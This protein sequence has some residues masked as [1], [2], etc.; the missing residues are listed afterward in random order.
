VH[1]AQLHI[2][3]LQIMLLSCCCH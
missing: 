1:L 3:V 2:A